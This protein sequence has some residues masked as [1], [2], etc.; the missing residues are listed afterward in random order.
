MAVFWCLFR[1]MFSIIWRDQSILKMWI[2]QEHS[3]IVRSLIKF[4]ILLRY[5]QQSS[6]DLDIGSFTHWLHLTLC[7]K[8]SIVQALH[9]NLDSWLVIADDENDGRRLLI[10]VS[11]RNLSLFCILF[12]R[13]LFPLSFHTQKFLPKRKCIVKAF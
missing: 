10:S 3:K 2:S 9:C 4:H 13:K 7:S 1:M 6:Y 12:G 8:S 5:P 11:S